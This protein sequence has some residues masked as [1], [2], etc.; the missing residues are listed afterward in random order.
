MSLEG[1]IHAQAFRSILT[2]L[3]PRCI[4][5]LWG[6]NVQCVSYNCTVKVIQRSTQREEVQEPGN[7]AIR[8]LLG[9][10]TYYDG[11]TLFIILQ[12]RVSA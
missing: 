8:H 4:A 5:R 7:Q 10:W 6:S 9:N 12:T 2:L 3:V 11:D 1:Y